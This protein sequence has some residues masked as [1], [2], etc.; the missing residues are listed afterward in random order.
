MG[1]FI[2]TFP[3]KILNG[4]VLLFDVLLRLLHS[5]CAI[6]STSQSLADVDNPDTSYLNGKKKYLKQNL[7]NMR[8]LLCDVVP[9]LVFSKAKLK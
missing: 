3:P 5:E 2:S 7:L 1:C 6:S 9:L 8:F 4:L